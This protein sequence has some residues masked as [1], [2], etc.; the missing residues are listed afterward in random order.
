[1]KKNI[2]TTLL[3]AICSVYNL[4]AQKISSQEYKK[5]Y[6]H[7]DFNEQ[8]NNFKVVTTSDNYFILDK[9]DYLLSRNNKESGY[10]IIAKKS[11]VSDFILKT[12]IR[13]GPSENK[14][15]SLGVIIKAQQNGQGA[16]IFEINQ[17]R[18]YRIKK[19]FKGDYKNLI[20]NDKKEGWVKNDVL[21]GTDTDNL[22]EI[23]SEKN[24]YDIYINNSYITTFSASEFNSGSCGLIISAQTKARISYYYINTKGESELLHDLDN[25]TT[26]I[27]NSNTEDPNKNRELIQE[28]NNKLNELNKEIET[29]SSTNR[30]LIQDRNDRISGLNKEIKTLNNTIREIQIENKNIAKLQEIN[31]THTAKIKENKET[32]GQLNQAVNSK[33][34][35]ISNLTKKNIELTSVSTKQEKQIKLLQN[36]VKDLRIAENTVA[37]KNNQLNKNMSGLKKQIKVQKAANTQL[38]TKLERSDNELNTLKSIQSKHNKTTEKLNTQITNLSNNNKLLNSNLKEVKNINTTLESTNEQLKELFVIK[39]FELS[40]VKPPEIVKEALR[41]PKNNKNRSRTETYSVQCGVYMCEQSY[42]AK[43]SINNIWYETTEKGTY[44][45]YSGVFSLPEEAAAH[46]NNLISE[47]YKDPF[48]VTMK[49]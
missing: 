30:E 24:N 45:Y 11:I 19:L 33:K 36:S 1:M 40:G 8:I 2:L 35:E 25:K 9:G 27:T 5:E 31:L 41:N 34:N 16:I 17:K 23:R 18:E 28:K 10:A 21:N 37:E 13:I 43:D 38:I 48:V 32:I 3:L 42:T 44:V 7:E 46:M 12:E 22:I 39:D 49:R 14:N 47:G 15:A 20:G 6:I 26:V 29:L 4:T